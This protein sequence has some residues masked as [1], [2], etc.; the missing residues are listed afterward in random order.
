MIYAGMVAYAFRVMPLATLITIADTA[1]RCSLFSISQRH[2]LL[3]TYV[4][5]GFR[6]VNV[7]FSALLPFARPTLLTPIS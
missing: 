4:C 2:T 1:L 6:Y 3:V 7:I 5:C